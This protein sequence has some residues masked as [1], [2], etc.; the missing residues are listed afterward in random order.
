MTVNGTAHFQHTH[1]NIPARLWINW[2]LALTTVVGAFAVQVFA[3]GAVMS[4]AACSSATCP[5]PS[6]FVYGFLT[7]G[8]LGIAATTLVVSFFTAKHRRGYLVPLAAWV[9]LVIDVAVM[10]LTFS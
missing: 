6:G 7:Y 8:A 1:H 9:L 2:I 5:K 4:T 3:M 10:S